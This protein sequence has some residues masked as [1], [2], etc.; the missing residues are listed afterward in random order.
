MPLVKETRRR[1]GSGAAVCQPLSL[2]LTALAGAKPSLREAAICMA[3]P[4]AGLRPSRAAVSLTLNLPKP[5]SDTSSPLVAASVI[6][7]KAAS[8]ALRASALDR[9][10][11]E[12]TASARS[13]VFMQW[14]SMDVGGL[15]TREGGPGPAGVMSYPAICVR[16]SALALGQS[17]RRGLSWAHRPRPLPR[18]EIE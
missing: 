1:I 6:A 2:S 9:F 4:V 16:P 14:F 13:E 18:R 8:T 17:R 10:A 11:A 12:A 15:L 7:A 3:A 5:F